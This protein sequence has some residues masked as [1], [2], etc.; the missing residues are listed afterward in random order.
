MTIHD[1]LAG[2]VGP[3]QRALTM[4]RVAAL[5]AAVLLGLQCVWLT[6]AGIVSPGIDHLPTDVASAT[7][8]T[9]QRGAAYLAASIGTIRGDLWAQSAFTYADLLW[10][11]REAFTDADRTGTV[12]HARTSLDR[13]LNDAPHRSSVWLLLAGLASRYPSLGFDA[14]EALR[15][16]YYTGASEQNLIPLRLDLAVRSD[17]FND[18]EMGQF[19]ERDLRRLLSQKQHVVISEAYDTAS[20]SGKRFIEQAIRNIDPSA[21]QLLQSGRRKQAL[22]D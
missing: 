7:V 2:I 9:K 14:S 8:A 11:D 10:G 6:L 4:L 22:P 21:L 12:A 19:V 18:F 15:M 16:A 17:S 1:R 5:L 13:A 3:S 20:P